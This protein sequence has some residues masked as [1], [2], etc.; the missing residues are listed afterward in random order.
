MATPDPDET[1]HQDRL[2]ALCRKDIRAVKRRG[3]AW[4]R[5]RRDLEGGVRQTAVEVYRGTRQ[6][7]WTLARTAQRLGLTPRT[8]RQ[9]RYDRG[10]DPVPVK[11]LGRPPARSS[12]EQRNEVLDMLTEYGP[13]I[14]VPTLRE[15]FP[16][17]ARA[18]LE[19]LVSRYRR[20]YRKRRRQAWCVLHWTEPGRVWA[21][22]FCEPPEPIEGGYPYLLAVRDLASGQQL[23]WLPMRDMTAAAT[24]LALNS[25]FVLEGVPLVL[26]SDNGSAFIADLLQRWLGPFGVVP[27]FSPPRRPEYNGSIE[28]GTRSLKTRAETHAGRMGRSGHWTF[29]DVSAARDEANLTARPRGPSGPSPEQAWSERE[30]ITARERIHFQNAVDRYRGDVQPRAETT[31]PELTPSQLRARDRPVISRALVWLGYLSITRRRIPLTINNPEV[32]EIP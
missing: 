13:A 15:S 31:V 4:Q 17:M 2:K 20:L 6:Q 12:A 30:L 28:A 26:K 27:L 29:D 11:T 5:P 16:T 3:S 1:R 25:L 8:L 24:I 22:D 7:G 18:E 19:N 32:P 23:L 9:W 14:G 21:M 10:S